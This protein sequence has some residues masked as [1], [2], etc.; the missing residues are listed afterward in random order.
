MLVLLRQDTNEINVLKPMEFFS[1]SYNIVI[2]IFR[3]KEEENGIS[4][5]NITIG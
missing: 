5:T 4:S 2:Q 3:T 1:D